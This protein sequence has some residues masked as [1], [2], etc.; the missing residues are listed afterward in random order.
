MMMAASFESAE[1]PEEYN[2]SVYIPADLTFSVIAAL[3]IFVFSGDWIL[4]T[5][6]WLT[7]SLLLCQENWPKVCVKSW[8]FNI[9]FNFKA[10]SSPLIHPHDWFVM[11]G[12][13]LISLQILADMIIVLCCKLEAKQ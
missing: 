3:V 12:D 4:F 2:K 8:K 6:I 10:M 1:K 7:A 9:F 11:L 5:T 13:E